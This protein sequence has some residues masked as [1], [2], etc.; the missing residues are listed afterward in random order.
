[1]VNCGDKGEMTVMVKGWP[2]ARDAEKSKFE[3]EPGTVVL[4]D[5]RRLSRMWK[6]TWEGE[7]PSITDWVGPST[8]IPLSGHQ[9][10]PSWG[11]PVH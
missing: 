4:K 2:S 8:A 6:G 11:G 10:P 1:M 3:S 5:G 7:Q 9:I